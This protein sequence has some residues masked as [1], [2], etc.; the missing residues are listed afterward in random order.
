MSNHNTGPPLRS[1][2]SSVGHLSCHETTG[3]VYGTMWPSTGGRECSG[4]NSTQ[5]GVSTDALNF[6]ITIYHFNLW[7][8]RKCPRLVPVCLKL[9]ESYHTFREHSLQLIFKL[10]HD[11]WLTVCVPLLSVQRWP[12]SVHLVKGLS[13]AGVE[14]QSEGSSR[15]QT[16][17]EECLSLSA[18]GRS[19]CAAAGERRERDMRGGRDGVYAAVTLIGD[20][21]QKSPSRL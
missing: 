7:K 11:G 16:A 3:A 19:G 6:L 12:L 18:C 9:G 5:F 20:T 17:S 14:A 10:K 8:L 2:D 15:V 21:R 4:V 13:A 1:D